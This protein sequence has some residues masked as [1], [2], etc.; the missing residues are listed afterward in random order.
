MGDPKIEGLWGPVFPLPNVAVHASLLPNGRVLFWGRRDRPDGTMDEHECTPQIWNPDDGAVVPTPQPEKPDGTKF[1]LFCSGHSFLPDGRLFVAGGHIKDSHGEN[2]ASTFDWRTG[3]WDALPPMN[4]GRWYPSV[5]SLSDGSVLVASGSYFDAERNQVTN[6]SNPQIWNGIEWRTLNAKVLSLY[7]RLHLLPN[8]DV[9]VAGTDPFGFAL[10]TDGIGSWEPAPS[11]AG[12]DR[13]YAPSVAVTP[14]RIVFVGGG[15]EAGSGAPFA[16][17]ESVDFDQ[18]HPKWHAVASMHSRR[19]QHNGTLLADG[20]LLVTGGTR[21]GGFDG[22]FNDLSPGQPVHEAELFD[23]REGSW[24][25]LAAEAADRCYH[26]T[27]VL[28]PDGTVL[29]AGG[30]EYF[31]NGQPIPPEHVHRSGQ[32]FSPPYLFRG[33][34]PILSDVSPEGVRYGTTFDVTAHGTTISRLVLIGLGSVTHSFNSGQRFIELTFTKTQNSLVAKAPV[35]GNTCPP[36]W[37]ML[38]AL[39]PDGVPSIAKMMQVGES[40]G[41]KGIARPAHVESGH[42]AGPSKQIQMRDEEVVANVRGT[43]VV[44]GLTSTCPYGLSAC[45]AG[46]YQTL[47]MLDGV[48]MV[49]PIANA[50]DSTAELYLDHYGLPDIALWSTEFKAVANGSYRIRGFEVTVS[51]RLVI[52]DRSMRLVS[53]EG[54]L[55]IALEPIGSLGK[56]QW[57]WTLKQSEAPTSDEATAFDRLRSIGVQAAANER[58]RLTGTLRQEADIYSL[59]VREFDHDRKT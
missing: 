51:G 7:P 35:D 57:D 30:G 38:F 13:Q 32:I 50:E 54:E 1:N 12:G 18:E 11:R 48:D 22:G 53:S 41:A 36:G 42:A 33:D 23:P 9:F 6:N 3:R 44:A 58:F 40:N 28:L 5:V 21:G 10:R 4:D 55:D 16:S 39:S 45:W 2:Q 26:S 27:A 14:G 25:V 24:T 47:K 34:R 8:G 59:A 56:V 31:P 46:A 20:S 43:R 29:S 37:Y 52:D 15:N 17:T 49:R 19:R